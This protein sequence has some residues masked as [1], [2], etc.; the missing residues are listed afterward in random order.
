M[1]KD[2]HPP[3][4]FAIEWNEQGPSPKPTWRRRE[5]KIFFRTGWTEMNCFK[6]PWLKQGYFQG[7]VRTA[8]H[9]CIQTEPYTELPHSKF[10]Q[11]TQGYC[12]LSSLFTAINNTQRQYFMCRW[13]G[14]STS[15][16]QRQL[17]QVLWMKTWGHS[18][19]YTL[20]RSLY[21]QETD[22]LW[23]NRGFCIQVMWHWGH[24]E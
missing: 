16:G 10:V 1:L 15:K 3:P 4:S 19:N 5:I 7:Q 21:A 13:G 8:F 23:K 12:S 20:P 11:T 14:V 2:P 22:F 9:L 17:T 24:N 6:N 18:V